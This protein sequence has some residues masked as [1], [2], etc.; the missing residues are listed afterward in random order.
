MLT[1]FWYGWPIV[2]LVFGLSIT[3]WAAVSIK[4]GAFMLGV[5][6]MS[7]A[8]LLGDHLCARK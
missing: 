4:A 5:L 6:T 8:V 1:R 2:G 3:L 7:V